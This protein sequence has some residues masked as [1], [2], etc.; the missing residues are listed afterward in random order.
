MY[1]SREEA[2]LLLFR[3]DPGR[4]RWG[5]PV[6]LR[7]SAVLALL[8]AGLTAAEISRLHTGE[9]SVDRGRL[10]VQIDR[11]GVALPLPLPVDLGARVLAWLKARRLW[12]TAE[13]VFTGVRGP[14]TLEGIYALVRRYRRLH[15][16]RAPRR[17]C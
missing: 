14:L 15:A 16:R 5:W 6:G 13:P 9:I 4:T 2:R 8:A 7:D 3:V 10:L 12:G 1:I 17:T 11:L